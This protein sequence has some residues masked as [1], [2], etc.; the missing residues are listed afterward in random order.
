MVDIE[1][2]FFSTFHLDFLTYIFKMLKK[3]KS[4]CYFFSYN[5]Y[6]KLKKQ[7]LILIILNYYRVQ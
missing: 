2:F 1:I 4:Y 5:Q 6:E 3:L 7:A